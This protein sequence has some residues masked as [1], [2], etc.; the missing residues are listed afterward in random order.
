M[1]PVILA[2]GFI[3]VI[4][5]VLGFKLDEKHQVLK[6][7]TIFFTVFIVL[8]LGR[9][10]LDSNEVCQ[11]LLSSTVLN[12][13]TTTYTY[14]NTCMNTTTSTT[15]NSIYK[16]TLWYFRVVF[17]YVFGF[18]IWLVGTYLLQVNNMRKAP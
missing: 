11:P 5:L 2:T 9:L 8:Y 7:L 1:I 6:V 13:N 3:G 15:P 16:T 14:T 17:V 18:L 4:L 12:A 10:T